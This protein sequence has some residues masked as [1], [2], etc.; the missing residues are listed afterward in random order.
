VGEHIPL[1][2]EVV[3]SPD[4]LPGYEVSFSAVY[5][6]STGLRV[7]YT[8]TPGVPLAPGSLSWVGTASDEYGNTWED[9]GG[10]FGL[11][12]DGRRTEGVLTFELLSDRALELSVRLVPGGGVG[13]TE[14]GEGYE[15]AISVAA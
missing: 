1:R 12:S 4:V 6:D 8:I 13:A 5:L 2:F 14:E 3:H 15:L 10:A 9:V 11:S 7:E